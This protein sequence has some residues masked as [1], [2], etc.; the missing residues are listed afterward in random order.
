MALSSELS[1]LNVVCDGI[2]SD[3]HFVLKHKRYR[4]VIL[5]TYAGIDAMATLDLPAD[6]AEIKRDDFID[7]CDKYMQFKNGVVTGL[8]LY[9]AR[10]AMLHSYGSES[11]LT[12]QRNVRQVGYTAGGGSEVM[13]KAEV[14]SL[15][16]VS[17]EGLAFAF[18]DG[19]AKFLKHLKYSPDKRKLLPERLRK[20]SHE[21]KILGNLGNV[22]L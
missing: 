1:L 7:W 21:Y 13:T 11:S 14:T 19:V 17:V 10:C 2:C 8:E 12:K 20:M 5:L 3:I 9:S 4:A 18:L 16:L 22:G 6:K 15:V